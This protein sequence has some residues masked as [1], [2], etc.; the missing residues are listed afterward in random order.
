MASQTGSRNQYSF[1]LWMIST[2]YSLAKIFA[3]GY[4]ATLK[5]HNWPHWVL[6][7][8]RVY[9]P[10]TMGR[11]YGTRHVLLL[12]IGF[13]TCL[14]G[15]AWL[16]CYDNRQ[17]RLISMRSLL[18]RRIVDYCIELRPWTVFIGVFIRRIFSLGSNAIDSLPLAWGWLQ[19][20]N[21]VSER[22]WYM[23]SNTSYISWWDH[24]TFDSWSSPLS[25][26]QWPSTSPSFFLPSAPVAATIFYSRSNIS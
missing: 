26:F 20:E 16:L 24:L 13:S 11:F 12:D 9:C 6:S 7:F 23:A 25:S 22:S 17:A 15:L 2:R 1:I 19:T 10:G 5:D 14:F 8:L 18:N 4:F 21:G 3:L